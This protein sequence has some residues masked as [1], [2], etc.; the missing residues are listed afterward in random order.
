MIA[1]L[2]LNF[3]NDFLGGLLNLLPTGVLP[4][5][6][7]SGVLYFWYALNAFSFVFPVN[8]LLAALLF[9]LAFDVGVLLW[10]L[11]QWVIR[12]IPGVS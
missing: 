2:F 12:K 1:T 5:G 9:V 7:T 11:V 8:A 10:H 6:I 4:S 3:F